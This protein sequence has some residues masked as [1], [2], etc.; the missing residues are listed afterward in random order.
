MSCSSPSKRVC[1][2]SDNAEDPFKEPITSQAPTVPAEEN[3]NQQAAPVCSSALSSDYF[4]T[5]SDYESELLAMAR[6]KHQLEVELLKA[7]IQNEKLLHE[8][9]RI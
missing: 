7:Q 6:D 8:F 2:R 1:N 9:Y 3:T 4:K 5:M